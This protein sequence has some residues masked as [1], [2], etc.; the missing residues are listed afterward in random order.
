MKRCAFDCFVLVDPPK[1]ACDHH[2]GA[3]GKQYR[4]L[5]MKHYGKTT[6]Q[7]AIDDA[8][9]AFREA[10]GDSKRDHPRRT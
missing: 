2:W 8:V 4:E 7:L 9:K 6:F 3:I 5:L 1:I 10:K